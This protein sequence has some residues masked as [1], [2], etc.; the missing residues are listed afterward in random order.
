MCGWNPEVEKD[1]NPHPRTEGDRWPSISLRFRKYFNPHPRT[2]GDMCVDVRDYVTGISTH[3]LARRVSG[4]IRHCRQR[5]WYFNPHPRTE[6]DQHPGAHAG[7]LGN[8]NPHPRTEGDLPAE[9]I[10][11]ITVISTHTLARRVTRGKYHH[12]YSNLISTHTLARRVTYL[13]GGVR[14]GIIDFNPHPRTE[15]DRSPFDG[16]GSPLLFQPTPSHG[17]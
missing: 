11:P 6:G 14:V 10:L 5:C 4:H 7:H 13:Y 12:G 2:E 16:G 3:T 8:F 17:G 15:G 9:C 1:F